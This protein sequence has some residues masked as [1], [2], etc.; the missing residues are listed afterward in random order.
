[1]KIEIWMRSPRAHR[2]TL[3]S[4]AGAD[5]IRYEKAG[6]QRRGQLC[7]SKRSDD[8]AR[9]MVF[10]TIGS[11]TSSQPLVSTSMPDRC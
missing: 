4:D 6:N 2:A 11:I 1:M 7:L 10:F 8:H 9:R 3:R 5:P